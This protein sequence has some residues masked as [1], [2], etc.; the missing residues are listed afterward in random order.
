MPSV[1]S[2][3]AR[4]GIPG[5]VGCGR[6]TQW[7]LG[8]AA[9]PAPGLVGVALEA[10]PAPGPRRSPAVVSRLGASLLGVQQN[11]LLLFLRRHGP[12]RGLPELELTVRE[13]E[14]AVLLLLR[15]GALRGI[16]QRE[17]AAL[18]LVI[19]GYNGSNRTISE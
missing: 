6:G 9:E 17:L 3:L 15:R 2:S 4:R 1:R 16:G 7:A 10:H 13:G 8:L 5:G 12:L 18:V 14:P 19:G 11:Q